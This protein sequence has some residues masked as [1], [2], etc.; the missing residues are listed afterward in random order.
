MPA[1]FPMEAPTSWEGGRRCLKKIPLDMTG[2]VHRDMTLQAARYL[3]RNGCELVATE[4]STRLNN[5]SGDHVFD[6]IGLDMHVGQVRVVEAKASRSDFLGD[7]KLWDP[8]HGYA[9]VA[10]AC[11]LICPERMVAESELPPSWGLIYHCY[12]Q[13]AV[14]WKD[15]QQRRR[16]QV[17]PRGAFKEA[18]DRL[19]PRY[20]H[21]RRLSETLVVVKRP[22]PQRPIQPLSQEMP[23]LVRAVG[24]KLTRHYLGVKPG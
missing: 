23:A 15:D 12:D 8:R 4:F 24:R 1:R 20:T 6:V 5:C 22:R 9:A 18:R 2:T 10:D 3:L 11:Y 7:P 19:G 13:S 21:T 16:K 14:Y 17:V